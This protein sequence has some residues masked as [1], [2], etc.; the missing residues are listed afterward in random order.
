MNHVRTLLILTGVSL[1]ALLPLALKGQQQNP[2]ALPPPLPTATLG[3]PLALPLP[4]QMPN[5]LPGAPGGVATTAPGGDEMVPNLVLPNSPVDQA[6]TMYENLTGKRIIRDAALAQGVTV[7]IMVNTPIKKS[8]AI[9]LIEATLL[10]NGIAFTPGPDNTIKALNVIGGGKNPRSEGVPVY[11]SVSSLP[12]GDQIVSYFMSLRYI[13]AAEAKSIFDAQAAPHPPYGVIVPVPNAQA[14][15][16]TESTSAIRQLVKIQKLID[17]PPAKVVSEFVTLLRADAEKVADTLTKM[18]EARRNNQ[19]ALGQPPAPSPE[20]DDDNTGPN[21]RNIVAGT[22]QLIPDSRTNRIL[23]ITRPI[24]FNYIKGLIQQFDEAA[25]IAVPF[26]RP[27]KYVAASDVLSVLQ[28]AL[29]DTK[30]D[31]Q[32]TTG[33]AGQQGQTQ[34]NTRSGSSSSSSGSS[35]V[36]DIQSPTADTTPESVIVGKTKLIADN[37]A[38]SILVM[39]PPESIARASEILNKLDSAPR[40]VYLATVIGELTLTENSEF[41]VDLLQKWSGQRH[42]SIASQINNSAAA[43]LDPSSLTTAAV[44]P[45][46]GGLNVYGAVGSTLNYYVK[47]LQDSGRFKILSRPS[48]Y[49]SNNKKA[50]ISS[51]QQVPVPGS[52]QSTVNTGTTNNTVVSANVEYKPVELKIAVVPL[53]NSDK[54]V[55]LQIAQ[56]NDTIGA[57][58]NI[59]GNSVPAINTQQFTTSVTVPN[60]QTVVLGGLIVGSFNQDITGLPWIS[61]IPLIGLLFKDTIK[62]SSRREVIIMIEPNVIETQ[63]ELTAASA[64][65]QG[66]MGIGPDAALMSTSSGIYIPNSKFPDFKKLKAKELEAEK[67]KEKEA[68]TKTSTSSKP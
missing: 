9:H 28:K 58:S 20:F 47:A 51:G 68:A 2:P 62:K 49:T 64:I 42:G 33:T 44:F 22:V 46:A 50:V 45:A 23:V 17:V 14:V 66:R 25:T 32:G 7:S 61:N 16:I 29:A 54:E 30:E 36:D 43:H 40:Q 53:I 15:I 31:A 12:Q 10:L 48:V 3:Q 55:T 41:G 19:T 24:N 35:V 1:S 11:A 65:E 37:R 38:N 52:T 60:R 39:G 34:K 27:L 5:P 56:K 21:E 13:S 67:Q 8:E 63:E 26:E 4:G 6:V 57:S 59:G 18:L